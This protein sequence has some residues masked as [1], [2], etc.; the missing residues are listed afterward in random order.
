MARPNLS[1]LKNVILCLVGLPCGV[2]SGLTGMGAS[3]LVTPLTRKLLSIGPGARSATAL[4]AT[5]ACALGALLPY[6]Q[7]GDVRWGLVIPLVLGQIFGASLGQ[8][9]ALRWA[10]QS[11]SRFINPIIVLI[12]GLAMVAGAPT[13]ATIS[14]G[15]DLPLLIDLGGALIV[16]LLAGALGR[17]VGLGVFVVPAEILLLHLRPLEAQGTA[18]V[19]LAIAS[20]PGM[21]IYR[22]TG[23]FDAQSATWIAFGG[24]FG[25]LVGAYNAV[26]S[27][28]AYGQ[29]A[30]Y[31]ALASVIGAF[32]VQSEIGRRAGA[33][34]EQ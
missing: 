17:I 12:A 16:G 4:A 24:L 26:H 13:I 15:R 14:G 9:V 3:V 20:L 25:G 29:V 1:Y 27:I 32:W 19:A 11:R 23:A 7:N 22:R 30:L 28:S 31:G 2:L 33:G 21:L 10:E 8:G 34:Q 18:I 5:L 6:S